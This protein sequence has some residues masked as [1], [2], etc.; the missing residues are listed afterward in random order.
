VNTLAENIDCYNVCKID[1]E[2]V[3]YAHRINKL[4][5]LNPPFDPVRFAKRLSMTVSYD[6]FE[7]DQFGHVYPPHFYKYNPSDY[8][9]ISVNNKLEERER[10]FTVAHEIAE[11]LLGF[12]KK[13]EDKPLGLLA[14]D[15]KHKERTCDK[16]AREI[17]IPSQSIIDV[18]RTREDGISLE[19]IRRLAD[20]Y[21]VPTPQ[22]A[23]KTM[24]DLK[25]LNAALHSK[26]DGLYGREDVIITK[27][28]PVCQL[29][30]SDCAEKISKIRREAVSDAISEI[31]NNKKLDGVVIEFWTEKPLPESEHSYWIAYKE[32]EI[33]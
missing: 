29:G 5:D 6:D 30:C 23:I 9:K 18:F 21:E 32:T 16:L 19:S 26:G 20:V 33:I 31:E 3:R 12:D 27:P 8:F 4:S 13:G 10:R 28:I 25:I 2:F 15:I 24:Y 22:M 17:L 1:Q 7:S 14:F 11:R